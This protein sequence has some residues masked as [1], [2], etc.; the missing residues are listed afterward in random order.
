MWDLVKEMQQ[1][2]GYVTLATMSKVMRRL[3]KATGY[4]DAIA[5]FRLIENFGVRQDGEVIAVL[6]AALVKGNALDRVDH[7]YQVFID[8]KELIL[9]TSICFDI[10]LN[11]F[12]KAKKLED[13]RKIMD[14]ME[15]HG[16]QP[17]VASYTSFIE[18]YC[19]EKDL[20]KVDPVLDEMQEKG[21]ITQAL[22]VYEKIKND[23]CLPD[24]SFYG[25]LISILSKGDRLHDGRK[26][27]EDTERQNIKP[28]V[29]AYNAMISSACAHSREE[30]ALKWLQKMEEDS[31]KPDHLTYS[32]LLHLCFR[33]NR[34]KVLNFLLNHMFKNDVSID[35]GIYALLVSGFCKSGKLELACSY[36]KETVLKGMVPYQS[37]YKVPVK[38]L[39]E[40][41]MV[42]TKQWIENLMVHAEEQRK[43]RVL[44]V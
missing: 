18:A 21:D 2:K 24:N 13:A 16:Y 23:G 14:E 3:V 12:C 43:R 28:N 4:S 27:F 36:F 19:R 9:L 38:E 26:I 33:K 29:W 40:K 10:L 42:E 1:F 32:P 20:S 44:G 17:N 25:L 30:E 11:G 5:A 8:F 22:E 37:T 6:M 34:M 35:L 7:A 15:K 39:G 31:C 41:N